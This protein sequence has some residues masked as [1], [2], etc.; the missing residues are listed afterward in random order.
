MERRAYATIKKDWPDKNVT[1]TSPKISFDQ[2]SSKHIS[3]ETVI[4]IRVGD[5][6]RIRMYTTL[7]FQFHKKYRNTFGKRINS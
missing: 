4:N 7:V 3:M 5:L 1:V 2:Y 6:L